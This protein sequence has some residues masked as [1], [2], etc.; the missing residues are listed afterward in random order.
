VLHF[1]LEESNFL[2]R[3]L[4]E[5]IDAVVDFVFGRGQLAGQTLDLAAV[6]GEIPDRLSATCW[7]SRGT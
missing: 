5:S 3:E 6:L 2:G 1:P 4:E 7:N